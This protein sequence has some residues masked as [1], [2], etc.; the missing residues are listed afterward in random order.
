MKSQWMSHLKGEARTL[1]RQS[2]QA[3]SGVFDRLVVIL[4]GMSK[5]QTRD[6]YKTEG[7]PYLRAYDD[8][9]NKALEDVK[10]LLTLTKEDKED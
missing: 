4:D 8:G 1:F 5:T 10:D 6:D 2:V 9:Y 7:W 3:S